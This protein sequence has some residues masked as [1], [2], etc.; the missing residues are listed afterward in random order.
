MEKTGRTNWNKA[1]LEVLP[2]A[3]LRPSP[4]NPS[5]RTEEKR[6]DG[7][8]K[9]IEAF[10]LLYPI[11]VNSHLEIVDGH[12]RVAA[13]ELLGWSEI[14]AIVLDGDVSVEQAYLEVA[15]TVRPP[16][17]AEWTERFMQGGRVPK[18]HGRAIDCVRRWCGSEYIQ[19]LV[20]KHLSARSTV[21][22]ARRV[23]A[24]CDVPYSDEEFMGKAVR[25][26]VEGRRNNLARRLTDSR[27]VDPDV[28]F[29][30]VIEDR[31]VRLTAK[32]SD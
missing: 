30:A 28:L 8:R 5:S 18:R 24:Y 22:V 31:D 20:E 13:V 32:L 15:T 29:R 3:R 21:D 2:L 4:Y 17:G 11:L 1:R 10:G 9:S 7:L 19:T 26:L 12:R 6:L 25:W 23:A 27:T 14:P 16:K